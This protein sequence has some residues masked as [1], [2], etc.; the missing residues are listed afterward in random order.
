M[1]NVSSTIPA[2]VVI[3]GASASGLA[4][5]TQL[6]RQGFLGR[7]TMIGDEAMEPYDRPPLSKQ[8]LSGAWDPD[9]LSLMKPGLIEK[10][11]LDMVLGAR[12]VSVDLESGRVRDEFG[13]HHEFDAL[14][15]ATGVRPRSL[16]VLQDGHPHVLR[17]VADAERLRQAL[18]PGKRLAVVGGGFLGLETAATARQL[19][20]EVVV[21]EPTEHPLSNR[22]GA[23]ISA[24][25][26]A[27]HRER[28]VEL[29]PGT[30][31]S[32]GKW[33]SSTA[34]WTLD[35]SDGDSI[36]ADEVLVAIGS[37]PQTDWL[38]NSGIRLDN[39]VMCDARSQAAPGVWA[40]GDVASWW[41]ERRHAH[42]R[43][44]H[45][46]NA[47]EQARAVAG[48]IMGKVEPYRPVPFFWTD[49]FEVRIQVAG[50]IG[51]GAIG[52]P[53]EPE[54]SSDASTTLLFHE[55]DTLSAVL[56]WNSPR[57]VSKYRQQLLSTARV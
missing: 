26:L 34:Q 27:L 38:A 24:R 39:G 10:L 22:L 15:V 50:V 23:D 36:P 4:T 25:L 33:D 13:R 57:E 3:V 42:V 18:R 44:E 7:M 12:A 30:S 37:V 47:T 45:R 43:L 9:K 14:V 55:G 5:A 1:T 51:A 28:G 40:V 19:G 48:A 29:R 2:S 56:G 11:N 54:S 17:T 41:D 49:H 35:L 8:F 16:D 31:V 21:I 46:T 6:R 20:A 32:S 52:V 53:V